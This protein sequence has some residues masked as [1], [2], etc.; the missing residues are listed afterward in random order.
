MIQL[1]FPQEQVNLK[2]IVSRTSLVIPTVEGILDRNN[3]T[4]RL[5]KDITCDLKILT[6]TSNS[7]KSIGNY[8][9]L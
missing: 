3:S 7:A 8:N 1:L 9:T 4:P 2:L 6:L 5:D